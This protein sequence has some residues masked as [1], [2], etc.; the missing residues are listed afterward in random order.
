MKISE[1]LPSSY[2]QNRETRSNVTSDFARFIESPTG[3]NSG[4][5]YY[6]QHQ[7][8]LQDSCL[9]F[10]TKPGSKEL[11][12]FKVEPIGAPILTDIQGEFCSSA[13]KNLVTSQAESKPLLNANTMNNAV[14]SKPINSTV[15]AEQ[16]KNIAFISANNT[17]RSNNSSEQHIVN[18]AS[19]TA[20]AIPILKKHHLF[21]EDNEAELSI[22][23]GD[24][25]PT[26]Q[27]ELTHLAKEYLQK[28]NVVLTQLIINGVTYD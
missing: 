17:V 24:L 9:D 7:S 19:L 2:N 1:Q 12:T 26:E 4:D 8:Q 11:K 6:W 15:S 14:V 25:N 22:S 5:E 27:K 20:A 13:T 23:T 18:N 16:I 21:I 3:N 10:A 28:K